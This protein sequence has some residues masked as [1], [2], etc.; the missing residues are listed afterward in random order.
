MRNF[1]TVLLTRTTTLNLKKPKEIN[2]DEVDAICD[3]NE[4]NDNLIPPCLIN[5]HIW[6]G[7]TETKVTL[8]KLSGGGKI[9]LIWI[10]KHWY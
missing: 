4:R 2:V 5:S 8:C 9:T 3:K 10:F 1:L 7:E 6:T